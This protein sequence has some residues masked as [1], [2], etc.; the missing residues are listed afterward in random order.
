MKI[1]DH[2]VVNTSS[3][4]SAIEGSNNPGG[5]ISIAIELH[6][7]ADTSQQNI[8]EI[9]LIPGTENIDIMLENTQFID[10]NLHPIFK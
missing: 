4:D 3:F 1:N 8:V 6:Q 5:I 9:S 2:A 10:R 7:L